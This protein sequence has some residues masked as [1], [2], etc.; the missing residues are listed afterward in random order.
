L[1]WHR[2]QEDTDMKQLIVS[3]LALTVLGIAPALAQNMQVTPNGS[4]PSAKGAEQYFTGSVV[5]QPLFAPT[6]HSGTSGGHV[7]FEPGARSAWHTHPGGQTL[8]V[9]SGSGWVQ[10]WNGEKRRINPGDVI[11]TPPGVKHWHGAAATTGM[12]HIA[13]T[14]SVDGKNVDWLEKVSDEQYAK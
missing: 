14:E 2:E 9:T 7:S 4:R 12:G 3:T 8:I 13:V 11:W 10:E 5:V 6:E 1:D